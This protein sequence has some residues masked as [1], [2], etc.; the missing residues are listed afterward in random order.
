MKLN[1]QDKN[2]IIPLIEKDGGNIFMSDNA[3][4]Y[5]TKSRKYYVQLYWKG[6]QYRRFHYD[7]DWPNMPYK[8]MAKGLHMLLM[9]I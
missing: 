9:Q 6:K 3:K 8:E 7:F 4:V 5:E 1:Y 2:I